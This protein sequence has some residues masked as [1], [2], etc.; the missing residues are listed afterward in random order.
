MIAT[1]HIQTA[2]A[3]EVTYLKKCYCTTPFKVA[4]ITEDKKDATLRLM[5][6]TSSPGILDGDTYQ[7]K[8]DLKENSSL[9]LHTQSYQRF[10]TMKAQATQQMEV[11]LEKNSAFCFIP[12]PAVPP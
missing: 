5:L 3:N 6:M 10:F 7:L 2:H 1:L 9:Q 8:I 11:S 4:N 12:H